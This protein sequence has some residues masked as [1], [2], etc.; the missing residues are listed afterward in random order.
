MKKIVVLLSLVSI[1]SG[2]GS[3][4]K[5]VTVCTGEYAGFTSTSEYAAE[6]DNVVSYKET[7]LYRFEEFQIDETDEAAKD[8]I[9]QAVREEN[10]ATEFEG[11]VIEEEIVQDGFQLTY[12][13][14]FTKADMKKV[15]E[16]GLIEEDTIKI[17]LE[18]TI[19]MA[20]DDGFTCVT[21]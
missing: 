9:L 19:S 16:M 8:A 17:S 15:M 6:G 13:L 21:E 7:I 4:K 3:T 18:K 1:L 2:C 12:F 20:E 11:L 10:N 5:T 14:D